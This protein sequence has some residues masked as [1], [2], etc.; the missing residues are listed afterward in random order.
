MP[1]LRARNRLAL[2]LVGSALIAACGKSEAASD[3]TAQAASPTK[4]FASQPVSQPASQFVDKPAAPSASKPVNKPASKQTNKPAPATAPPVAEK[5]AAPQK[6]LITLAE[7]A[8][9][10][11]LWPAKVKLTKKVGFSPTEVYQ[12]GQE[13]PLAE[14]AGTNL[15]VDTKNGM[16][17]IPAASTDVVE[18]A[19]ALMASL[20]PEQ[21]AVTEQSLPKSP[22][23]WPVE[24]AVTHELGFSGGKSVPAGRKV[25]LRA[26][27]NGQLNVYDREFQNYYTVALNETDAVARARDRAKLAAGERT[28][29]FLRSVAATLQGGADDAFQKNDYV[30]VY[31]AR[32]DCTRCAAFLPKLKS[33]YERMKPAHPNFEVVFLSQD[34]KAEDAKALDARE[35]LPGR[36]V[37]YDKRLEA[38]DL[39]T[40]V[41]N[42]SLLPLVWLYDRNGKLLGQN[43]ASGGKPAAEDLLA[44]L[45][46]KLG[47]KR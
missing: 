15:H 38:A 4:A 44:T 33:F 18:R 25:L 37:A 36:S 12:A 22:E 10:R 21:L 7:L 28:P 47:E 23:L 32:L 42:G 31:S 41:Q 35:H 17:E 16:I 24:L 26:F 3:S 5:P 8:N 43:Q 27:E 34:F 1:H 46:K 45:E 11:D 30:L 40:L 39:G 20:T 14:I 6:P 19:S 13:L 2:A 29:F 9:R